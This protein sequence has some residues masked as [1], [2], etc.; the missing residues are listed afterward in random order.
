M[1][2]RD[3]NRETNTEDDKRRQLTVLACV[4]FNNEDKGDKIL[5]ENKV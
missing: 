3:F 1:I 4:V 2:E 5:A